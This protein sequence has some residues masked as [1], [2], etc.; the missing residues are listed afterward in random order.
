MYGDPC[1]RSF[2][3]L[4]SH[5]LLYGAAKMKI[6]DR[7]NG[8]AAVSFDELISSNSHLIQLNKFFRRDRL[9]ERNPEEIRQELLRLCGKWNRV[10]ELKTIEASLRNLPITS[11]SKKIFF[12]PHHYA[13]H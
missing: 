9:P 2:T 7:R 13:L 12:L 10:I 6:G 11:E 8:F 5:L 1:D 3:T 4:M